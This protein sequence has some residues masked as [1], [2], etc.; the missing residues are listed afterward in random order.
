MPETRPISERIN[1][2]YVKK[3]HWPQTAM[4][5]LSLLFGG[6]MLLGALVLE[7]GQQT[8]AFAGDRFYN[9]GPVTHAHSMFGNNCA[10]CHAS[11]LGNP[12]KIAFNL[13]VQDDKCLACHETH[14]AVHHPDIAKYK[15]SE[16]MVKGLSQ[17]IQLAA[18]CG[19]CHVEHQGT[20]TTSTASPTA[21]AHSAT[22]TWTRMGTPRARSPPSP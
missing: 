17:P 4:F 16:R 11:D 20:T 9:S 5:K 19:E 1:L 6:V 7:A 2:A 13:P 18:R 3:K 21:S 10:A 14:A 12:Q 8:G 22:R 15:G